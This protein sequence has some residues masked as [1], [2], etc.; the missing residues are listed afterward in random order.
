MTLFDSIALGTIAIFMLISMLRGL[1][2]EVVSIVRWL[3]GLIAARLFAAPVAE[4]FLTQIHPRE[5]AHV[6]AFVGIFV[7]VF[8]VLFMMRQLLNALL[9]ALKLG[10]VNRFLGGIF[11]IIKGVALVTIAVMVLS[12]TSMPQTDAWKNAITAPFFMTLGD[13]ASPYIGLRKS[14]E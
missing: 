7:A 9:T 13:M 2:N 6:V 5:L 3:V 12:M 14:S 11:G 8:I 1:V 4:I 10:G